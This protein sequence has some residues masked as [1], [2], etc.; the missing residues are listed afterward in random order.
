MPRAIVN[1]S[2]VNLSHFHDLRDQLFHLIQASMS[3]GKGGNF[4]DTQVLQNK[5]I[6]RSDPYKIRLLAK[7][8][9]LAPFAKGTKTGPALSSLPCADA[10]ASKSS[11]SSFLR[12][13]F[14]GRADPMYLRDDDNNLPN[15]WRNHFL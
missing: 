10:A 9:T 7:G 3:H 2:N 12:F 11:P 4:D 6:Q 8:V 14:V 5:P 15:P 1:A 13:G